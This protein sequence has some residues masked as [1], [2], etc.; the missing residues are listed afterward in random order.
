MSYISLKLYTLKHFHFP[1][2]F[3]SSSHVIIMEHVYFLAKEG[4][5]G[6][7]SCQMCALAFPLPTTFIRIELAN[8]ERFLRRLR[9]I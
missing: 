6:R 8:C 1:K 7:T 2:Y 5:V 4:L 9:Y 3:V